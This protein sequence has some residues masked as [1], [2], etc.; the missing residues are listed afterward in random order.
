MKYIL[1]LTGSIVND[2]QKISSVQFII[3]DRFFHYLIPALA[4]GVGFRRNTFKAFSENV[5]NFSFNYSP[6]FWTVIK[7]VND[8]VRIIV[9]LAE[10]NI[11]LRLVLNEFRTFSDIKFKFYR[12]IFII[13]HTL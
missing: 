11:I 4:P 3:E 13:R 1:Y 10:L 12:I 6:M 7:Q 2:L 9:F 5:S 8:V